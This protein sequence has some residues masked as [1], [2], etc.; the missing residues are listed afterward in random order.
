M[1]SEEIHA[2]ASAALPTEIT[3][4]PPVPELVDAGTGIALRVEVSCAAGCAPRGLVRIVDGRGGTL[5]ESPLEAAAPDKAGTGES[6]AA[7]PAPAFALTA[8]LT[9][10]APS[11]PGGY[12]WQALFVPSEAEGEGRAFGESSVS[13][14]FTVRAHLISVYVWGVPIPVNRGERFKLYAGAACSAG[15]SLAGLPLKIESGQGGQYAVL[16]TEILSQTKATYWA[17]IELQAPDDEGVHQWKVDAAPLESE[18]P[19]E[20]EPAALG[21][22]TAAR[23]EYDITIEVSDSRDKTPLEGAYVMLGLYRG[24]SD[25]R[26]ICRLKAPAGRQRL[27]VNIRDYLAYEEEIEI[28]DS[29][30]LSA[31]LTFSPLL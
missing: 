12:T 9:V 24:E 20:T 5:A 15:C 3:L 16:G 19:H 7:E 17:E 8:E 29:T 10:Q 28:T 6:A 31:G 11:K 25:S 18:L 27:F 4:A 2:D 26:G 13:F 21:F 14:S 30:S 23:P 22:R 1:M